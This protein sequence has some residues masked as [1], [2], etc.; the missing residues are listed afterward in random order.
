HDRAWRLR[1]MQR[2]PRPIWWAQEE[3]R[4]ADIEALAS[5]LPG[6]ADVMLSHEAPELA[7]PAVI[8]ERTDRDGRD[9]EFWDETADG[10]YVRASVEKM[11]R[12]HQLLDPRL[13]FHGHYHVHDALVHADGSEVV[14]VGADGDPRGGTLLLDIDKMSW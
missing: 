1:Y 2:K 3:I 4:D 8:A 5:S 11:T 14:S 13:H 7:A 12:A 10:D 9:P 6:P